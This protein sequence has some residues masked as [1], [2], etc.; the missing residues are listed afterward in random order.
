MEAASTSTAG[1]DTLMFQ[2]VRR[3]PLSWGYAGNRVSNARA[4]LRFEK[5]RAKRERAK[6]SENESIE[7]FGRKIITL[8]LYSVSDGN[9]KTEEITLNE[10]F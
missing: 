9:V 4:D 5:E 10:F 6:Y 1:W 3:T 7:L 2:P 8:T